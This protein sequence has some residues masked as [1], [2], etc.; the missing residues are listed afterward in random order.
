MSAQRDQE[1]FLQHTP[2]RM[3]SASLHPV[4]VGYTILV[5]DEGESPHVMAYTCLDQ[6]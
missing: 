1:P 4:A 6:A 3:L 2:E 5:L